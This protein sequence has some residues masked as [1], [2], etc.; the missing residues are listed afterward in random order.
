[1]ITPLDMRVLDANARYAGISILEAMEKAGRGV[2]DFLL[3]EFA[4]KG[5]RVAIL[6]GTG[7]NGGD[8]LVAAW[9]LRDLCVVTLILARGPDDFATNEARHNWGRVQSAVAHVDTTHAKETIASADLIVD[10]LLGIGARPGPVRE[11]YRTLLDVAAASG[12]PIISV[13]IPSGLGGDLAVHPAATVTMHDVKEGMT[14]ANS[15][16]ITVVDVGFSGEPASLIGPGDFLYYPIPREDSHKGQNGR[17][18]VIGGGPFTGAPALAAFGAYGIGADVVHVAT[19][20]DTAA[21]VAG[22]SPNLIVHG[23]PGHVLGPSAVGAVHDLLEKM[24]ALVIGPGL[25]DAADTLTAIREI[26][27]AVKVPTVIDA[28]GITAVSK[29]LG[30]LSGKPVVVTPHAREYEILSGA[31]LPKDSEGR[32]HRVREL[33]AKHG[34]TVLLKGKVDLVTDGTQVRHNRTGNA[35]MTVGGTGD[36]L[37]GIVGGLLAKGVAPFPAARMAAFANGHAGD[38]AFREKSYGLTATDVA[39]NVPAVLRAFVR[40]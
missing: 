39:A 10:A 2:S 20:Q 25:G 4:A 30:L 37:A 22:Y 8:G 5:K 28:D 35:G 36:V 32:A 27:A 9:H 1:V 40:A 38:L 33:A 16:R 26:L 19:P 7:N 11:P 34:I 29:D 3:K 21:V 6:V 13:D 31:A 23:L 17:L 18:L 12:K 15:G 14:E 24:D